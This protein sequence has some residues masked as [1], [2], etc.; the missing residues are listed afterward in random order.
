MEEEGWPVAYVVVVV[1]VDVVDVVDV[2]VGGVESVGGSKRN[3]W[4]ACGVPL[5]VFL[6][7]FFSG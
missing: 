4:E 6:L 5:H 3:R 1:V 7:F 2:V